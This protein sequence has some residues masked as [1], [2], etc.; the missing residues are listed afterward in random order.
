V[1]LDAVNCEYARRVGGEGGPRG[2]EPPRGRAKPERSGGRPAPRGLHGNRP[3]PPPP[4]R[5]PTDRNGGAGG[6]QPPACKPAPGVEGAPS[7]DEGGPP[8]FGW[9]VGLGFTFRFF[10]FRPLNCLLLGG[11]VASRAWPE[12]LRSTLDAGVPAPSTLASGGGRGKAGVVY[13]S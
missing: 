10:P 12:G 1:P 3:R 8:S 4:L 9:L 11:G 2:A 13:W 6:A 5:T 7:G